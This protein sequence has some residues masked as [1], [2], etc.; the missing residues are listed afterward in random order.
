MAAFQIKNFVSIVASMVNRM[1]ITQNQI[2]DF[3][4]G[5]VGRTLVEAPAAEIDQL[6]QQML[7]GLMQAIPVSVYKS[8]SFPPLAASAATGTI[9]VTIA[10]SASAVLIS[11]GTQ[12]SSAASQTIY[13]STADV[14][15][16]IGNT[17]ANVTV[18]A[19]TVGSSTNIINGA[20]FTM[21]PAPSGFVSATNPSP[22]VN[23]IDTETPSQQKIRF[24]SFIASLPRGT[25]A[26]LYYG[27]SLATVVDSNN[28]VIERVVYSSVVEPYLTDI[29]QPIAL[30]NC[31]IHNGIGSTSSALLAQAKNI[32]YGYYTALGVAVPGYKAA[33]V[34]VKM[35]VAAEV[36]V[37]VSGVI[38]PMPGYSLTDI[39]VGG[40]TIS[41][42]ETLAEA[43]IHTYLQTLPIGSS[44]LMA[45]ITAL[46]M[47]VPGVYNY[48]PTLPATDVTVNDTQKIVPGTIA[49]T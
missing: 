41:G 22:F 21:T 44:A 18:S 34:N 42:L 12:F 11:A 49:I 30:V 13:A 25:V 46:V 10:S 32:I 1:K 29:T 20:S 2:T 37:N 48:A 3:N 19:M 24:N 6:Y 35:F 47:E 5:A 28:N 4:I 8:F 14:I 9:V 16:P 7:N 38:T 23:A 43:A 27:M 39:T 17:V 33:G 36:P 45:E 40:V 31:Y 26:A 15:I